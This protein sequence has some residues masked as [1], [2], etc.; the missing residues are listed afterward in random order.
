MSAI[1]ESFFRDKAKSIAM[2]Y[3]DSKNAKDFPRFLSSAKI[4]FIVYLFLHFF[5]KVPEG[6]DAY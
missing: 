2:K 4:F 3:V 5:A 1:R 6:S